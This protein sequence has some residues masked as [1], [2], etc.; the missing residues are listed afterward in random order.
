M[1]NGKGFPTVFHEGTEGDVH[2]A[3]PFF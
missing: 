1:Q 3:V 2:V